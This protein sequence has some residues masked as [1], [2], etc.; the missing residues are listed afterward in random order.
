MKCPI[1]HTIIKNEKDMSVKEL[2]EVIVG[3]VVT[4]SSE[5]GYHVARYPMIIIDQS[6]GEYY[7]IMEMGC[8]STVGNLRQQSKFGNYLS[9]FQS[10]SV[11][12]LNKMPLTCKIFPKTRSCTVVA[13]HFGCL[14]NCLSFH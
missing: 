1:S 11:S 6:H 3:G 2:V 4:Q 9:M 14:S 7:A 5:L 8:D 10:P 12:S 13:F